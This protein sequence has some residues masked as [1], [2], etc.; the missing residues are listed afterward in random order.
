MT[1]ADNDENLEL[2]FESIRKIPLVSRQEESILAGKIAKGDKHALDRLV[3]GNLR[4]VVRIAKSMWSPPHSLMDLIQEGN[5]GLVKAAERFD[6]S[7]NVKFST[8]AVWWIRQAIS[9]SL[10]NTGRHIR[11]PHRKE[12]ALRRLSAI[13]MRASLE[14]SRYP[15]E[16]E[17]ASETGWKETEIAAILNMGDQPVSL[18]QTNNDELSILDVYEDWRYNPELEIEKSSRTWQSSWLLSTLPER[19]QEVISKRFGLGCSREQS[20]K[21]V[22]SI[23]GCSAETVRHIE[24]RALESLRHTALQVGLTA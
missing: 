12:N 7:K 23:V 18:D 3:E 20:L 22:G 5:I 1:I 13:Q 24:K 17:L 19:E 14:L 4:L 6:P 10:V 9:R 11:L 8:Y 2:Y 15:S 21:A 16:K